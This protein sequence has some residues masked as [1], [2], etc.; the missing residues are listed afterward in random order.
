MISSWRNAPPA[1]I[2]IGTTRGTR[3]GPDSSTAT[4]CF[5]ERGISPSPRRL[6]LTST[7]LSPRCRCRP[8]DRRRRGERAPAAR[9]ASNN[10]QTNPAARID[11]TGAYAPG[12]QPG[13]RTGRHVQAFARTDR[14]VPG[15]PHNPKVAG[16]NPAPA[17]EADQG[18]GPKS[19][20]DRPTE[21]PRAARKDGPRR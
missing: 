4:C 3:C 17:I 8:S 1:G 19:P 2:G 21:T 10:F 6:A 12:C 20:A 18:A 11:T 9:R 13:R 15:T 5:G 14:H 7:P 16:S